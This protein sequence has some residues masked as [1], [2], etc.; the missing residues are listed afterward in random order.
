MTKYKT[1][2]GAVFNNKTEAEIREKCLEFEKQIKKL[3]CV[4]GAYYCGSQADF[5]LIVDYQAHYSPAYNYY[6]KQMEP[7][8][9]YKNS[10]YQGPDW[11][12]FCHEFY[13][14]GLDEYWVETLSEKKAK[15]D[16]FYEQYE[17]E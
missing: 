1:A 11:Y 10:D 16:E 9:E 15:W 4:D 13:N 8:Y 5:N 12:F 7:C 3:K 14:D 6:T 17:L 2:D